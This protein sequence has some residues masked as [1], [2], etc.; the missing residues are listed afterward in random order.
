MTSFYPEHGCGKIDEAGEV[1]GAF[2]VASCNGPVVFELVEETLN[3]VALGVQ[4]KIRLAR[5]IDAGTRGNHGCC[6]GTFNH[7]YDRVTVVP[8][9]SDHVVR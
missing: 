5:L 1:A 7:F 2:G 9:V 6:S 3:T 8:P 4:G